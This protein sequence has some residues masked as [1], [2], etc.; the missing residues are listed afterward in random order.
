M[1]SEDED[2][3]APRTRTMKRA[4]SKPE[5]EP[6]ETTTE[7]PAD[8]EEDSL[9]LPTPIN[10]GW[11]AGQKVM[12]SGSD[13]AQALRLEPNVQVIKF[14]ED[15]PYAN[16]RRH[17]VERQTPNGL[18]NRAYTCLETVGRKCPLCDS[19]DRPQA[20]SAFNIVL[21]GDDGQVLLKTWDVGARIFN[22]LKA[23]NQDPKVGPLTKGFFAVSKT[24][25][26]GTSAT[27][28][29]PI[30]P[31]ALEQDYEVQPPSDEE[32][33]SA[34]KYDATIIQLP[35]RSELEEIALELA[36]SE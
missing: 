3:V 1:S 27:N 28:V 5:T 7:A 18:K 29:L 33:A 14:L 35:K 22:Q 34:G 6:E 17:W 24:G 23:F 21:V 2:V 32:L 31:S 10:A 25:R 4:A 12:D 16:Y 15:A 13:Y 20:V 36:E 9:S 30:R 11:T 26:G 19:G 8:E